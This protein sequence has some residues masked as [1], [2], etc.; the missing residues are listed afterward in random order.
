MEALRRYGLRGSGLGSVLCLATVRGLTPED[1]DRWR[2][3]A[4][5]GSAL[6]LL[7]RSVLIV[8]DLIDGDTTRWGKPALHVELS[9][10]ASEDGRTDPERRG[11][12]L[13]TLAASIGVSCA[14]EAVLE[15]D[16]PASTLPRLLRILARGQAQVDLS[17]IADLELEQTTPTPEAWFS[18]A[19]HRAAAHLETCLRAGSAAAGAGRQTEEDLASAARHLG[20]LYDIRADLLDTFGKPGGRRTLGRD[21]RSGKRPLIVCAALERAQDGERQCLTQMLKA[22]SL[23][24]KLLSELARLGGARV[25]DSI[26]EHARAARRHFQGAGLTPNASDFFCKRIEAAAKLPPRLEKV[27][28]ADARAALDKRRHRA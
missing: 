18:M 11:K 13:A 16:S 7:S 5:L 28:P 26:S 24:P 6:D 3:W 2:R 10:Y 9:H 21:I 25:V 14:Y 1:R 15:L 20:Y 17:Q 12:M 23:T 8:D 4:R 22:R 19:S 27:L